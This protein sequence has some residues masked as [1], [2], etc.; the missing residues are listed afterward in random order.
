[1]DI[2]VLALSGS[3]TYSV[4]STPSTIVSFSALIDASLDLVEFTSI[5]RYSPSLVIPTPN[6]AA[7]DMIWCGEKPSE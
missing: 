4:T 1:M 5:S 7:K 2:A 6:G 3:F